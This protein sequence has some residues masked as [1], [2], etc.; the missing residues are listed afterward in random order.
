MI[1]ALICSRRSP[2]ADL[3]RTVLWR[4]NVARHFATGA[5]EGLSKALSENPNI[6]M[7]DRDLHDAVRLVRR[8]REEPKTRGLSVVVFAEGEF[9]GVDVALLES[10]ANAILR[11][12]PGPEWDDRLF[13]L[14]NVPVRRDTRFDIHLRLEL[15]LGE[16]EAGFAA[17]GLNLSTNGILVECERPLRLGNDLIFAFRLP[18]T[19]NLI[20]GAGTVLRVSPSN[21]Y[22]IEVHQIDGEGHRL[23][24]DYVEGAP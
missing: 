16:S 22:G 23:I 10:G 19:N 18:E 7:V 9:D 20:T 14:M 5:D 1:A 2:E 21:R 24:R 15:A 13:R 12:P 6:V 17:V 11:L 8:I 3:G 4:H